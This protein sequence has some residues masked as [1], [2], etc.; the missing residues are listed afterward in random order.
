MYY[1]ATEAVVIGWVE[2]DE[3]QTA[4]RFS[5]ASSDV[6]RRSA[7]TLAFVGTDTWIVQE[8][9]DLSISADYIGTVFLL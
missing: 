9:F 6:G 4:P 2:E 1:N 3:R 7:C 8:G 5:L